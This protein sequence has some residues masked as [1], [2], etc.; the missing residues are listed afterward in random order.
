MSVEPVNEQQRRILFVDDDEGLALLGSDL[1]TD[2]GYSVTSA[3][4]GNAAL[5]LF[6]QSERPFD[7]IITDE[8][9]P[10]ISG[11]E[12]AQKI[13]A[14]SPATPVIL[15]SGHL[16]TMREAGMEETNITATLVKTAVCTELPKMI[17]K[18]FSELT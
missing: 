6:E 12:L 18:I 11:I 5:S 7:L 17:D 3:F 4:N 9:M 15:C 14:I 16:L 13:F 10:G 1:L 8:T 2:I